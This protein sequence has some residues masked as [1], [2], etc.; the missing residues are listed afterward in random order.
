MKIS[1][2]IEKVRVWGVAG[3]CSYVR[4][5]IDARI[6]ARRLR[7]LAKDSEGTTP[8]RGVTIIGEMS[9]RVSLSKTL[10]DFALA[11]RDA[12]IP[13]QVFDTNRHPQIP[14]ADLVASESPFNLRKYDHVVMMYRSPLD[15][16]LVPELK[17]AR[18]V[19]H[20]SEHGLE[21]TAPYLWDGRSEILA[22]SDFNCEYYRRIFQQQRVCKILY[23]L[24]PHVAGCSSR[25]ALR[26]KYGIGADDFVVYFNFDFGSYHRKN[27][28]AAIRAFARA[29]ADVPTAKLLFKTKGADRNVRCVRELESV[30]QS[31]GVADRFVH[32]SSYLP[33]A[34][35]D[36]LVD[37][38][39]VYL[40]LHRGEG[41]GLGMAEAM[42]N[43]K[44]VVATDWSSNTEFCKP[45]NS[46][47]IPYRIVPIRPHEYMLSMREWAEADVDA[48]AAALR[49]LYD[50]P[51]FRADLGHKAQAFIHDYF[52]VGTFKRSVEAWLDA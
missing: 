18:I 44:P 16:S 49:K 4:R 31:L 21:K 3:I 38:C 20:E 22:M 45:E 52:T 34:D 47:P 28:V 27:A 8:T 39:D 12:G 30:A 43:A 19:F 17:I 15:L 11:L 40:S 42:L 9:G 48:A 25:S 24:R 2:V 6:V 50:D 35:V 46:M 41:F 14:Q 10:R 7:T 51:A 23:P 32:L 5:T 33:R 13:C 36:G 1:E 29:F 26:A 37:V